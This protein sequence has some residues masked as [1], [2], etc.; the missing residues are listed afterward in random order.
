MTDEDALLRAATDA[1]E[2]RR[3]TQFKPGQSGNPSGSRAKCRYR[4]GELFVRELLRDFEEH[5]AEAIATVRERRPQ[6]YLKLV[7]SLVPRHEKEGG[8][9]AIGFVIFD[10]INDAETLARERAALPAPA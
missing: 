4:L 8:E 2:R 3:A 5:G 7:A 6:D 1:A 10:R 9:P